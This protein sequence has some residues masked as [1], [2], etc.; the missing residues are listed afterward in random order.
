[1]TTSYFTN[2]FETGPCE[3]FILI[4]WVLLRPINSSNVNTSRPYNFVHVLNS[5]MFLVPCVLR[6]IPTKEFKQT[7]SPRKGQ[8]VYYD[9]TG[10]Q[11]FWYYRR[12]TVVAITLPKGKL[13]GLRV[14]IVDIIFDPLS[15]VVSV[16]CLH[17]GFTY[18]DNGFI[19]VYSVKRVL[20]VF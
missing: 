16:G 11:C 2:N 18:V 8:G 12:P 3:R 9:T 7:R 10:L 14:K 5:L 1:M 19:W 17:G 13:T 4:V 6:H 20:L 15:W